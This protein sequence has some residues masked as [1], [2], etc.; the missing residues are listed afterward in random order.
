[1]SWH[2]QFILQRVRMTMWKQKNHCWLPDKNI[3]NLY[4]IKQG[5]AKELCNLLDNVKKK[6]LRV[7]KVL[8][9]DRDAFLN[10]ILL[11]IILEK[12]DCE[13]QKQ[14]KLRLK[15]KEILN[16]DEFL[17]FLERRCQI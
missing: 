17:E 13:T 10:T 1:M 2:F 12:L 3:L 8:E 6:K 4:E 7:L 5:F 14:F 9:F 16:F 11:N 15:D